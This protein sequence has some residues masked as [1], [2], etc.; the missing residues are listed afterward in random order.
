MPSDVRVD[1]KT[2]R[3]LGCTAD[4]KTVDSIPFSNDAC[5]GFYGGYTVTFENLQLAAHLGLNPIYIIGCDHYY[6]GESGIKKDSPVIT[7]QQQNHFLPGYRSPGEVVNPAPIAEM[8]H[9]YESAQRFALRQGIQIFNASR[10]G[11]LEVFPRISLDM[12][13]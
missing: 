6:A 2:F 11:H 9:S 13:L 4:A 1:V 3:F 5:L 10:G 8:T 12:L 7:G